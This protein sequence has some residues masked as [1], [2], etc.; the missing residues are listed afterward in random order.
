MEK[1]SKKLGDEEVK[2]KYI[3]LPHGKEKMFL[4]DDFKVEIAGN[5][6]IGYVF[7]FE[8]K[9]M[10]SKKIWAHK[11]MFREPCPDIFH[12]GK[13]VVITTA[14]DSICKIELN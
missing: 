13:T 8:S 6:Y 14:K 7:P 2:D 9:A 11:L 1:L 4:K 10:G 3:M 12:Y 5:E